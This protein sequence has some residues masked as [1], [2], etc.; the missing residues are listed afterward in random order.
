MQP[1]FLR[2]F[3]KL[4]WVET[5]IFTREDLMGI[6]SSFVSEM[7]EQGIQSLCCIPLTT[8]KGELGTLNLASKEVNAFA[9]R[10][11]GFLQQIAGQILNLATAHTNPLK[12]TATRSTNQ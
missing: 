7:L 3:W 6:Q 5:K 12:N 8:R 10:D 11:V 9:P 1:R 2:G 4:T